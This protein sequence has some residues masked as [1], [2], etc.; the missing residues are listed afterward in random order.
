MAM[1]EFNGRAAGVGKRAGSLVD[2]HSPVALAARLSLSPL[3]DVVR[4]TFQISV[5]FSG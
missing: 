2:L 3:A 4:S 1:G 5:Y